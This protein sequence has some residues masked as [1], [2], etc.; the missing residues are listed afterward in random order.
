[1]RRKGRW[2]A[3]RHLVSGV[4]DDAELPGRGDDARRAAVADVGEEGV[5]E[6]AVDGDGAALERV[7]LVEHAAAEEEG[8]AW[9]EGFEGRG[10]LRVLGRP[11]ARHGALPGCRG[12]GGACYDR[13]DLGLHV[14]LHGLD[15]RL[16]QLPC[17]RGD[18][19]HLSGDAVARTVL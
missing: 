16:R 14:A 12:N 2:L 8:L 6:G 19:D 1:M 15:L 9:R 13:A 5:E 3:M 17:V 11:A 7:A 10:V 18:S 4:L